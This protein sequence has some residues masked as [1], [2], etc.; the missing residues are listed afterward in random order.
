MRFAQHI[1]IDYSGAKT[2]ESRL[3]GLQ[4]YESVAGGIPTRIGTPTPGT[5]HWTRLEV[6]KF[7]ASAVE[8]GDPVIIGIDHAFSFPASYMHRNGIETWDRFMEDF[9]RHWPTADPHTYIDFLRDGNARTGDAAELRLCERWTS[10]A[11]SVFQFD[12]Q[13]Q[14]AKSTHAGIPWLLWLREMFAP[15]QRPH[16]WPFDGFEVPDGAH[17]IAEVYPSLFRRRYPRENRTPDEQDAFSVAAW[18]V[19]MD[20]RDT[21]EYYFRPPLSLPESKLARLEGWILGVC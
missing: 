12:V 19:D 21:L 18:L 7:C 4:V 14:V 17:V 15:E 5:K 16:F 2:P 1:G 9:M 8:R 13:G 3:P 6:A 20:R 11:K 10:G